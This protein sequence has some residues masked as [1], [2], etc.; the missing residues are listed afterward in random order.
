MEGGSHLRLR[1]AFHPA[2]RRRTRHQ[3]GGSVVVAVDIGGTFTDIIV[4]RGTDVVRVLKKPT[5]I[6]EPAKALLAELR[7]VGGLSGGELLHATTIATNA[8]LSPSTHGVGRGIEL[9]T[10][11][12]FRDIIEIGRQNRPSLYDLYFN[13]PIPLVAVRNRHEVTERVSASG[14]VLIP[15]RTG[16]LQALS[17]R[18][19]QRRAR[20]VAISFLHSYANPLN[21]NLAAAI[22]RRDFRFVSV[23]S[24]IAPEPREFERTSTTVVNALL[25]PVVSSYI[26][27]L[28]RGLRTLGIRSASVMAS[29]GGLVSLSEIAARPVQAVESGPAAGVVAAAEAARRIGLRSVISFDMGGTTAKAGTIT[30]GRIEL[31]PELEVSGS[32]H[33]GR[34][35]KGSGYPVRFPFVDLAEVSSGGG[36]HIWRDA[37]GTLCVGPRSA[38]ST[39]GPM[40]Y[41]R[42]GTIPTVTDADLLIGV[43]GETLLGGEMR[44]DVQAAR[45]GL[46]RLGEPQNVAEQALH[47]ADLEMA[48]GI[49]MVTVERGLDPSRFTLV[50]FGGAGPQHGARL[51]EELG[52]PEVVIPRH[53]GLFSALGLLLSDWQYEA[54]MAFP[55]NLRRDVQRLSEHLRRRVQAD[56]FLASVECR[57]IGQGSELTVP[58]TSF[59]PRLVARRFVR[60]HEATF[61]FRL[62]RDVELVSLRVF[63]RR[64]RS[65][66]SVRFHPMGRPNWGE[67]EIRWMGRGLRTTTCDR[68]GL[69]RGTR[70]SG[71]AVIE[72]YGATTFVPPAWKASILTGG[73]IRLRK[74]GQ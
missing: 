42:G 4:Q 40:C 7:E 55:K 33:H 31:T 66:P 12:G 44:L 60:L 6:E 67:R 11:R 17:K 52:I 34:R 58:L 8:F 45:R 54:R 35:G 68:D 5:T 51:A 16:E 32:S 23:S 36:T 13:R 25:M 2:V 19:R 28:G 9:V 48:R 63:A 43:L 21:E 41:G 72:E 62:D 57:Y 29:S 10:T 53:P 61:G 49:R 47:L 14:K 71:P 3:L 73:Q 50:A 65:K 26:T 46:Q 56:R 22:L 59:N 30:K 20:A 15:A 27:Q 74:I 18:L 70:I 24:D 64:Y 38:G 37:A 69:E 39:P 1:D